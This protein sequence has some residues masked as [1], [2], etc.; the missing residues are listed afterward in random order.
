[1]N[2]MTLE[3]PDLSAVDPEIQEY[4]ESLETELARLREGP[5][6]HARSLPSEP[7][8]PSEPPT[9]INV[10]TITKSGQIKRTPR[11]HY[12]RQRRGGMG[13]FDIDTPEDDPPIYLLTADESQNLMLFTDLAR[14]YL[15]P[16]A[17]IP[18]SMVRERGKPLRG[19]VNLPNGE[20]LVS[21]V[22]A[23]ED[24]YLALLSQKGYVR[25]LRHNYVGP[26]MRPGIPLLDTGRFG[27]L[28]AA[29]WTS[30]NGD[31]FIATRNGLAIRFKE[32]M[33]HANG[34]LGIRLE[35]GDEVVAVCGTNDRGSVFLIGDDGKGTIRQMEGFRANKAPGGGGKVAMKTDKLVG[36]IPVR[37][38]DDLF[39]ISKLSKII[40]FQAVEI[41][42]KTGVVQG[43]NCISLRADVA[44]AITAGSIL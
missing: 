6:S 4:I 11:H 44:T 43:V 7:P 12:A 18:E 19:F 42:P 14:G 26:N 17:S 20:E 10:I 30:G 3:R 29:G 24:G 2:Q 40:R 5:R 8:E 39:I 28:A 1:M 9:T 27:S 22:P 15:L 37:D 16:V 23:L 38:E 31:V 41:P 35:R 13:V 33:V 21:V 34:S 36:A 32:K 25:L